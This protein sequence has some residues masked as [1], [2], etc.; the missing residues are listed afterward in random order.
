LGWQDAV[1]AVVVRLVA[2]EVRVQTTDTRGVRR[3]DGAEFREAATVW[4][5]HV[6]RAGEPE[7]GYG[8]GNCSGPCQA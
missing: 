7:G 2:E 4:V 5:V 6:D 8:P 1:A 3:D